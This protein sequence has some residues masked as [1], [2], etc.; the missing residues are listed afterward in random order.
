MRAILVGGFGP[1]VRPRSPLQRR[2][3]A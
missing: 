3:N 2:P 1:W